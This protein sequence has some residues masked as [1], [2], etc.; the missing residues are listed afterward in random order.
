[1]LCFTRKTDYALISLAHL[2]HES[3]NCCSAR[4]IA[5]HYGMPLPLVMNI[6][7]SLAQ[8]DL[9]KSERG[10]RGGYTLAKSP[11]D[12]SLHDIIEAVDGPVALVYCLDKIV[13]KNGKGARA[14]GCELTPNCPVRSH[15]HRVHHRLVGFLKE[16]TLADMTGGPAGPIH[17]TCDTE[18]ETRHE[19]A[20]LS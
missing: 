4:E 6:L 17:L 20:N 15:V 14:D 11:P 10:P 7:K 13:G 9:I 2:V 18:K 1:M 16:V 5:T 8:H 3:G 12:I 19:I